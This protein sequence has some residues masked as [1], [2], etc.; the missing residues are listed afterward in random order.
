VLVLLALLNIIDDTLLVRN[1]KL[2]VVAILII[3]AILTPPDPVSQ[4]I[5][6]APMYILFEISVVIVRFVSRRKK[7]NEPSSTALTTILV[8]G[9]IAGSLVTAS[10]SH[11]AAASAPKNDGPVRMQLPAGAGDSTRIEPPVRNN[12]WTVGISGVKHNLKSTG[13]NEVLGRA[14][15]VSLGLGYIAKSWFTTA[16]VDFILGPY[17][18]T[19]SNEVDADYTGTGVTAWWGY[20]AQTLD[21]RS[22]DGGYGFAL[23]LSYADIIGRSAGPNRKSPDDPYAPENEGLVDGYQIQ[24]NALS[25]IPAVFFTWLA[26]ARPR[27]NTPELLTTRLEGWFLTLGAAVPLDAS[28]KAKYD[29]RLLP[30]PNARLSSSEP[31]KESGPLNGY[32]IILSLSGLLGV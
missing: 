25:V 24:V 16:A 23:G 4:I 15:M 19:R 14:G 10:K 11:A 7:K 18:P 28:F 29:R 6:A 8:A 12:I 21:L 9:L 22:V 13:A 20:S 17:E 26:P 2:I 27:G 1:R 31:V 30:D 32:S 5:M 3:A